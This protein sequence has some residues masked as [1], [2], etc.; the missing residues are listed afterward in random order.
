M[1]ATEARRSFSRGG[2]WSLGVVPS[3]LA[4]GWLCRDPS[5]DPSEV[6]DPAA[7]RSCQLVDVRGL[8]GSSPSFAYRLLIICLSFASHPAAV[9]RCW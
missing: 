5:S 1:V 6:R 4:A 7:L 9:G 2:I 3:T 8:L